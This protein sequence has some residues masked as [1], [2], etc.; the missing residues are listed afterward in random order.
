MGGSKCI[1]HGIGSFG[2]FGAGLIGNECRAVHRIGNGNQEKCPNNRA[3]K[4][5][6]ALNQTEIDS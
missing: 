1:A 3:D 2:S 5:M 4:N 6:C